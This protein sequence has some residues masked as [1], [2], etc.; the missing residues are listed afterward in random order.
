VN[1]LKACLADTTRY[2]PWE[3]L[4][5]SPPCGFA[6]SVIGNAIPPDDEAR[7]MRTIAETAQ[8]VWGQA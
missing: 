8:D 7:Q 1:F 4:A 6:I 2:G 3:R 5:L